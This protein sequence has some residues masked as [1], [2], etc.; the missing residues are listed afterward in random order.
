MTEIKVY[1]DEINDGIG[2]LVKA[3]NSIAYVSPLLQKMSDEVANEFIDRVSPV[4]SAK[5]NRQIDRI[6]LY[7]LQTV[8]VTAGVWNINTDIFTKEPTWEARFSAQD[9]PFNLQHVQSDIIGHMTD[10]FVVDD[11][12]NIVPMDSV[13]A[14]VPEK[15]HIVTPAVIY[16][17]WEDKAKKDRIEKIIAEIEAGKKWFVSMECLFSDFD[18]GVMNARGESRIIQRTEATAGLTKFLRQFG[19]P[20]V[21]DGGYAIGRVL[22]NILFSGK[23]L[24]DNPANPESVIFNNV[25][26]FKTVSSKTG[27]IDLYRLN[28]NND[29][30]KSI[31]AEET[32][33]ITAELKSVSI[34]D[35]A[36]FKLVKAEKEKLETQLAEA[37]KKLADI[38]V[39]AFTTEIASLKD[40]VSNLESSLATAST[41]VKELTDTNKTLA[42]KNASLENEVA[43][44][45]KNQ[46]TLERTSAL[47]AAGAPEDEAKAIVTQFENVSAEQFTAMVE[48]VKPKWAVKAASDDKKADEDKKDDAKAAKKDDKDADDKKDAVKAEQVLDNTKADADAPLG[49]TGVNALE[50]TRASIAAWYESEVRNKNNKKS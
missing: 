29:K 43:T 36:A 27:Y 22:K 19:G 10:N 13:L 9:K 31:M 21:I 24:T 45:K 33:V 7:P 26:T 8:L 3:N 25:Q 28:T 48:L 6:D 42:E 11:N 1:P 41:S 15:F 20:G 30:G 39:Q 34:E 4:L 17:F 37:T 2:N 5:A 47:V 23:G 18:Y 49:V 32:K 12:Y 44:A 16:R 50:S 14:D 35:N 38:N 46:I 40:K